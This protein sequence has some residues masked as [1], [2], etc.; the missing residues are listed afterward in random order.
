M[1]SHYYNYV[2]T[3][4]NAIGRSSITVPFILKKNLESVKVYF[5][6]LSVTQTLKMSLVMMIV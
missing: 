5:M 6:I 3:V 4:L 2:H 1:H